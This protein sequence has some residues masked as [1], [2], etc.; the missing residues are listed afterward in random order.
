MK[1]I[2]LR[3]IVPADRSAVLIKNRKHCVY[4]GNGVSRYFTDKKQAERFLAETNRFLNEKIFE[5]NQLYIDMFGEY[6]RAWFSFSG[7]R[8]EAMIQMNMVAH[9]NQIERTM[10]L[11]ISRCGFTNGNHFV[12]K[13]LTDVLKIMGSLCRQI[14]DLR[15][16]KKQYSE[17]HQVKVIVRRIEV[18]VKDVEEYGQ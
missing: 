6:R 17:S 3:M 7:Q 12:F 18:A 5:I 16:A 15:H 11:I 14:A 2:K 8:N 13:H 1:K 4:L 9:L 10:D